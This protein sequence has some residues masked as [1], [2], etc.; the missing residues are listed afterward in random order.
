M[1]AGRCW[2]RARRGDERKSDWV[3][4]SRSKPLTPLAEALA[5]YLKQ[6]GFSRRL[7]QAGVVEEWPQ[8]VGP[9]VA[10]VTSPESVTP[11]GILRVRVATAPWANE[12]SLMTPVIL[13]RVNAGR[14]G[15]IREIRWVAGPLDGR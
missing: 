10:R 14:K 3:A 15:R 2:L 8:L 7:A 6:S 12:L 1:K 11:D 13:A 5:S 4:M 9:Q